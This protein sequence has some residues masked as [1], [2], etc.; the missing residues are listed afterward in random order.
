MTYFSALASDSVPSD[1][2]IDVHSNHVSAIYALTSLH[3]PIRSSFM[4]HEWR[5]THMELSSKCRSN[6]KV[7]SQS[8]S[9]EL[10]LSQ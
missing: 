7:K 6:T 1:T 10:S 9:E 5:I 8:Y 2:S 3:I 4:V